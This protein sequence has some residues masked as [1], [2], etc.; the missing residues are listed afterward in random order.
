MNRNKL[1]AKRQWRRR[2]G[3]RKTVSG[4][5]AKPRLAVFRSLNHIYAQVIDDME[6][7][8]IASASTRD[9]GVGLDKSGNAEAAK[10]VGQKLA[11]KA[12]A[13][14]VEEV[15]FDRGGFRFHGRVKSLADGARE[16]GLKF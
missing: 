13:K 5:A 14:G 6:G 15:V 3:I 8:T 12:K 10:V 1:K 16:G 9:K 7:V 11:E 2:K 4:T